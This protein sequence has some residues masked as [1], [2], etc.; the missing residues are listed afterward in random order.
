MACTLR[1]LGLS[2]R[3]SKMWKNNSNVD[4]KKKLRFDEK[5]KLSVDG[6]NG[7]RGEGEERK[8]FVLMT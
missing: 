1:Q 2:I 5:N 4:G 3:I 8:G 7:L 6:K